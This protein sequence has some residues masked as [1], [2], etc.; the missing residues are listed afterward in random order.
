MTVK[1]RSSDAQQSAEHRSFGRRGGFWN[2]PGIGAL[3][4]G[5]RRHAWPEETIVGDTAGQG[6]TSG[7]PTTD[8]DGIISMIYRQVSF[9]C[10]NSSSSCCAFSPAIIFSFTLVARKLWS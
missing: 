7:L 4:F 3:G 5:G 6:A 2:L 9:E 10:P 1:A 8:D